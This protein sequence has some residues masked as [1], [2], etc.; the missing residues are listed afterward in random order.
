MDGFLATT[1]IPSLDLQPS[2]TIYKLLQAAKLQMHTFMNGDT[3]MQ[4]QLQNNHHMAH[5]GIIKV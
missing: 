2:R 4:K 1:Y 3:S 5:T